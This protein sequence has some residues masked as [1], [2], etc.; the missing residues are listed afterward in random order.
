MTQQ[1]TP[2]GWSSSIVGKGVG[3]FPLRK[4][5][6]SPVSGCLTSEDEERE[7]WTA[8]SLR[9]SLLKSFGFSDRDR[10]KDF[11]GTRFKGY[12]IVASDVNRGQ[13]GGF[14]R[15]KNGG[16]SSNVVISRF[17]VQVQLESLILAQSERWRQ[18]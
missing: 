4:V 18:A 16:T 7:T 3:T 17:K 8:E 11:G 14:G 12:T 5:E 10:T 13:L 9:V 2:V 15:R 6:T 1:P